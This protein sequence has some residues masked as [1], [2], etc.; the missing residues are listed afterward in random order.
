MM[1]L[2]VPP[3]SSTVSE[4][5]TLVGVML[6]PQQAKRVLEQLASETAKHEA[7]RVA[8]IEA[9][10]KAAADRA[11]ADG[12]IAQAEAVV[13]AIQAREVAVTARE[14]QSERVRALVREKLAAAPS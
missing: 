2:S 7:A 6:D 5:L 11:E 14:E 8:A 9:Q 4:A 3:S 1:G 10:Q 13:A 12:R